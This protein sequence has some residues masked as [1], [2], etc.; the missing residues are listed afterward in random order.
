[1]STSV[2]QWLGAWA[3]LGP[4]GAVLAAVVAV[5]SA[6]TLLMLAVRVALGFWPGPWRSAL[7][8][9]V[10]LALVAA[11]LFAWDLFVGLAGGFYPLPFHVGMGVLLLALLL[12]SQLW[13]LR[14]WLILPSARAPGVPALLLI[15]ALC[16]MLGLFAVALLGLALGL[17]VPQP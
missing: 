16:W 7:M 9:L 17:P 2:L 3:A 15:V 12:F 1:M 5:A 6:T 11:M 4:L 10:C 13:V 14:H 8:V